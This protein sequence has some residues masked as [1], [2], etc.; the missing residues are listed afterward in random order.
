MDAT[1]LNDCLNLAMEWGPDWLKPTQDRMRRLYPHLTDT[2]LNQYD[3]DAR[4][5]MHLGFDLMYNNPK[6]AFAE[7]MAVVRAKCPWVTEKNLSRMY[8]QGL[9][10]ASK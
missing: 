4:A 7:L 9:Y 3:T 8:S 1:I 2:E 6:A 10:Y 5:A